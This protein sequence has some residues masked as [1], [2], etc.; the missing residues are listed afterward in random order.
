MLPA[1][2]WMVFAQIKPVDAPN[3]PAK[4]Q[5]R[6]VTATVRLNNTTQPCDGSG[7]LVGRA[8]PVVYVLTA[9]HLA[10]KDDKIEASVFTKDSFPR[11]AHVYKGEVIA[12]Q[13]E[14]DLAVVRFITSDEL[15]DSLR[16][17][18]L[19]Q[20]PDAK[21]FP[22]LTV[23]C[24][25]GEAP[26]C[27]AVVVAGKKRVRRRAGEGTALVWELTPAPKAGRSGGP[28][29]DREGRLLG[30]CSGAGDGKGYYA[31]AE[32]VYSFLK[33]NGLEFLA[34]EKPKK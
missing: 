17:Y 24:K 16:P 10:D 21:D 18:S 5:E 7:V 15:P 1:L 6:A 33:Q 20:I 30:V 11:A 22:G 26:M 13:E 4:L 28:L 2:L 12:R 23:G 32:A 19:A 34:D 31:H 25:D 3:F 29:L 27:L 14:Q 9:A 8:G